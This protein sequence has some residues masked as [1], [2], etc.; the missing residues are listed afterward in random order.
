MAR[1][2]VFKRA[3]HAVNKQKN[4]VIL[5][6]MQENPDL[7]INASIT[8]IKGLKFGKRLRFAVDILLGKRRKRGIKAYMDREEADTEAGQGE[9][10]NADT[11][12]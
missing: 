8:V 12:K 3:R 5:Q 9:V 4:R 6:Y 10:Q 2:A 1:Q 7:V 11:G